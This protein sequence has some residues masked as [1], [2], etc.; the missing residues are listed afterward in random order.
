MVESPAN[1]SLTKQTDKQAKNKGEKAKLPQP[2]G[3]VFDVGHGRIVSG[4]DMGR[5]LFFAAT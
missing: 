1:N 5:A 4:C 3:V 2:R